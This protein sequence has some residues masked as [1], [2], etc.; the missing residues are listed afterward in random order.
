MVA[1]GLWYALKSFD[2]L[3][4]T[5]GQNRE[6][7]LGSSKKLCSGPRLGMFSEDVNFAQT[8]VQ[9][10]SHSIRHSFKGAHAS[11]L[12]ELVVYA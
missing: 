3:D 9:W 7:N 12:P 6:S 8:A 10:F 11:L 1:S 4:L 5:T 2:V